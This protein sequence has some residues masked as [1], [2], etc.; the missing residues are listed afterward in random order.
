MGGC[1]ISSYKGKHIALCRQNYYP[2]EAIINDLASYTNS[3]YYQRE[4][5]LLLLKNILLHNFKK[6]D[7]DKKMRQASY[8]RQQKTASHLTQGQP[9]TQSREGCNFP[10]GSGQQCDKSEQH[11][12]Q[13]LPPSSCSW[14]G[15]DHIQ[16]SSPRQRAMHQSSLP[17][18]QTSA[19]WLLCKVTT[20]MTTMGTSCLEVELK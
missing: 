17:G 20:G 12:T 15:G 13:Y 2:I 16:A 9:V 11:G 3:I 19:S 18:N 5:A 8:K 10:A 6:T 7:E 1:R 14:W 4:L